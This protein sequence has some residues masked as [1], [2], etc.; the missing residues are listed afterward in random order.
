[1]QP[2]GRGPYGLG[3]PGTSLTTG[4]WTNTAKEAAWEPRNPTEEQGLR[5]PSVPDKRYRAGCGEPDGHEHP[6]AEAGPGRP[7]P[8]AACH[9]SPTATSARPP[10]QPDRHPAAGRHTP[11]MMRQHIRQVLLGAPRLARTA[12]TL[13]LRSLCTLS[14]LPATVRLRAPLAPRHAFPNSGKAWAAPERRPLRE[15]VPSV[16]FLRP[17]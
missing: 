14:A 1:M 8:Q 10:P 3:L 17:L 12:T 16:L 9:L 7:A 4:S 2:T 11:Q 6:H 13:V 15:N 5:R